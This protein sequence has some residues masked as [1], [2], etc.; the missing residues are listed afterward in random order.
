MKTTKTLI[1]ILSF[2]LVKEALATCDSVPP[3][4]SFLEGPNSNSYTLQSSVFHKPVEISTE[5]QWIS[6]YDSSCDNED[7]LR[8][9]L[10]GDK[11]VELYKSMLLHYAEEDPESED[12]YIS[13]NGNH[14]A[15]SKAAFCTHFINSTN[16]DVICSFYTIKD[17]IV[18]T[19]L[20]HT[21][22]S[23][24]GGNANQFL[25]FLK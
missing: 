9:T 20:V 18:Q 3:V 5:D 15:S 4:G 16:K 8:H 13:L 11:A 22:H 23:M 24:G 10:T 7:I 19:Q 1:F 6:F 17:H 2:F 14:V 25:K 12:L 21:E